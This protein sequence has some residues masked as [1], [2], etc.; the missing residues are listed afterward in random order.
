M[1]FFSNLIKHHTSLFILVVVSRVCHASGEDHVLVIASGQEELLDGFGLSLGSTREDQGLLGRLREVERLEHF[2]VDAA[3][4][5]VISC[6]IAFNAGQRMV[7]GKVWRVLIRMDSVELRT[8]QHV[9]LG[10]V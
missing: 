6:D 1:I 10:L 3:T 2:N 7:H 9:S 4:E 8:A 5:Y